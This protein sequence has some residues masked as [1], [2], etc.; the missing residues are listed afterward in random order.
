MDPC[1]GLKTMESQLFV[2]K[3]CKHAL[4][5]LGPG[6]LKRIST[7]S[8]T[9]QE[10]PFVCLPFKLKAQKDWKSDPVVMKNSGSRWEPGP[11]RRTLIC[12]SP[13]G[14]SCMSRGHER[15][16]MPGDC[17]GAHKPETMPGDCE[18]AVR[19]GATARRESIIPSVHDWLLE[20]LS[21]GRGTAYRGHGARLFLRQDANELGGCSLHL[22]DDFL[23]GIFCWSLAL[24]AQAPLHLRCGLESGKNI[25]QFKHFKGLVMEHVDILLR[26]PGP[27]LLRAR[28]VC[29]AWKQIIDSPWFLRRYEDPSPCIIF[30]K[31]RWFELEFPSTYIQSVSQSGLVLV[32]EEST[33][34]G[35]SAGRILWSLSRPLPP[36]VTIIHSIGSTSKVALLS[37]RADNGERLSHRYLKLGSE[38]LEGSFTLFSWDGKLYLLGER[39]IHLFGLFEAPESISARFHVI[40]S[41]N[42]YNSIMYCIS[43]NRAMLV[44]YNLSKQD[45]W[46]VV[47]LPKPLPPY[48]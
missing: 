6:S 2:S 14:R 41:A 27:S 21:S 45:S 22:V 5:R 26:L 44:T 35:I 36:F 11:K 25:K 18:R 23:C 8:I 34:M 20:D 40:K 19:A 15:D 10:E 1:S 12:G 16:H 42:I 38:V 24:K 47:P 32:R 33:G 9:D 3:P 13:S 7:C 48:M 46:E 29:K 43:L 17:E 28:A 31:K 37:Y 39:G 4:N 30:Q